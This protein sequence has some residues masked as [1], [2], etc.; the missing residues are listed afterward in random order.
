M[1]GEPDRCLW[2]RV[3][4]VR[5]HG[6]LMNGLALNS[7]AGLEYGAGNAGARPPP[8][9]SL[10]AGATC[11]HAMPRPLQRF[12]KPQVQWRFL[13]FAVVVHRDGPSCKRPALLPPNLSIL[14][15]WTVMSNI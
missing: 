13:V 10:P 2:L 1:H 6:I 15:I 8:P 5:L 12:Q 3:Q 4:D 14:P 7:T 11:I 9:R